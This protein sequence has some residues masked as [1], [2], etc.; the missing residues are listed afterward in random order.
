MSLCNR[1]DVCQSSFQ[2]AFAAVGTPPIC[3]ATAARRSAGAAL[4]AMPLVRK[5]FLDDMRGACCDSLN[6]CGDNCIGEARCMKT[7]ALTEPR[8]LGC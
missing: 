6:L 8:V 3:L 5:H 1:L 7:A 2:L 4:T